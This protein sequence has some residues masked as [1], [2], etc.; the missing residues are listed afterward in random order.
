MFLA[1]PQFS[2]KCYLL[3]VSNSCDQPTLKY[4]TTSLKRTWESFLNLMQP[5]N[6]SHIKQLKS[7]QPRTWGKHLQEP[8]SLC[9]KLF[10][11][12]IDDQAL[13]S[14][15]APRN[16]RV[17]TNDFLIVCLKL[18]LTP[19]PPQ[20]RTKLLTSRLPCFTWCTFIR[21][22]S[23]RCDWC[24][25]RTPHFSLTPTARAAFCFHLAPFSQRMEIWD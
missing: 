20:R 17:V 19:E 7:P 22:R 16:V 11:S 15:A 13:R 24:K 8:T 5:E 25:S 10:D 1:S 4:V 21:A 12:K 3:F 18:N 6:R 14:N 2:S 9:C 23:R